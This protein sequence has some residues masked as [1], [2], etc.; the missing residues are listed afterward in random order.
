[1]L[2][3][4]HVFRRR[5]VEKDFSLTAFVAGLTK[6]SLNTVTI[7]EIRSFNFHIGQG[8]EKHCKFRGMIEILHLA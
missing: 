8:F 5:A 3:Q 6:I 1:M 4:S 2:E 7:F